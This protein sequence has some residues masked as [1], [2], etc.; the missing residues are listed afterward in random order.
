MFETY[1]I[2]LNKKA[3]NEKVLPNLNTHL[4][5]LKEEEICMAEK[6]LLNNVQTS[7]SGRFSR[8]GQNNQGWSSQK[9]YSSQGE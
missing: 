5:S 7:F 4:K 3:C 1:V 8:G 2:V 6:S 9:D